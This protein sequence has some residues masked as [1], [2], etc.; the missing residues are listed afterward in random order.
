MRLASWA[1]NRQLIVAPAAVRSDTQALT[2]LSRVSSSALRPRRQARASTL[3][4]ISAPGLRRG[5]LYLASFRAWEC[6][7]T[8]AAWL[9]A[10]PPGLGKSR[11]ARPSDGCSSC[12]EP[13]ESPGYR[14]RRHPP[15][16]ASGGRSPAW[17]AS[18]YR[19][20]ASAPA[21]LGS[22]EHVARARPLVFGVHTHRP[23]GLCRQRFPD[24]GQHLN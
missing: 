20:V 14:D 5:R 2:A 13:A 1:V 23:P 15:A 22:Q 21:G 24:V 18:F 10:G 16:S 17:W 7:G 8:P 3:D 6:G 19:H 4:S 11:K 9:C 12:P